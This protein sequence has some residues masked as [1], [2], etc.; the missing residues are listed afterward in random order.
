ME[1]EYIDPEGIYKHPAFTSI[2]TVTDPR[3]WHFF[4]GRCS[5]DENYNCV[6]AGDFVAQYRRVMEI[7]DY[8][9]TTVGATW[10]DVVFRRIFT[11]DVDAFLK[12]SAED[13]VIT[14]YWNPDRMPPS[15]L[16]GVTRL[17]DPDFLIEIDLMA[18]TNETSA[19][20]DDR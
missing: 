19:E 2:V 8:E 4:A 20:K 5:V 3:K 7:L 11:L 10:D 17:S 1:R 14:G 12:A 15:T 18:V 6:S 13:P 16:I 9:L